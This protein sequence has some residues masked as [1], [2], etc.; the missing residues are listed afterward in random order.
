MNEKIVLVVNGRVPGPRAHAIATLRL[1]RALQARGERVEIW[2]AARRGR[3]PEQVVGEAGDPPIHRLPCYDWID[4]APR[5]WQRASA[6]LQRRSFARSFRRAAE[7]ER[8]HV[9]CFVLRDA[10]LWPVAQRM[11]LRYLAEVHE[12]PRRPRARTQALFTLQHA[13]KVA[14]LSS[15]GCDAL[16]RLGLGRNDL[17]ALPSAADDRLWNATERREEARRDLGIAAASRVISYVGHLH[18]EKGADAVIA[19]AHALPSVRVRVVGGLTPERT[20]ITLRR[21][22]ANLEILGFVDRE[23]VAQEIAAADLM[24][25]P[26]DPRSEQAQCFGS[27]MK[28]AEALA[29]G[30]AL[31]AADTP[32]VRA[33]AGEAAWF[34]ATSDPSEPAASA[35][36]WIEDEAALHAARQRAR[37][38]SKQHL[39][40][41]RA[42]LLLEFL[43]A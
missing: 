39:A 10:G 7:L 40:S 5:A 16:R 33:Q 42:A 36:R 43:P 41:R 8:D 15:V 35:R 19:V 22:P 25:A 1:G 2:S 32:A 17:H 26:A 31:L 18:A 27:S 6:A 34:Y 28:V 37:A 4:V 11:Q 9:R 23:R 38:I 14:A 21:P 24:L 12:L 30:A 20:R 29:A 13:P 3:L